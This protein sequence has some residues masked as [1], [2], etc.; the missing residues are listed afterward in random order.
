[1]LKNKVLIF[2]GLIIFLILGSKANSSQSLLI[3]P[4]SLSLNIPSGRLDTSYIEVTNSSN[5][6]TFI[7]SCFDSDWMILF[8][9]EFKLR[10]KETK[11]I[12]AIF[13]VPRGEDPERAGKIIFKTK[14][15]TR[16]ANIK[17][18]ILD[19]MRER[20]EKVAKIEKKQEENEQIKQEVEKEINNLKEKIE[21]FVKTLKEE[22][23]KKEIE[24][25]N[26]IPTSFY[27][28]EKRIE[29]MEHVYEYLADNL[30]EEIKNGEI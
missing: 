28:G 21:Y 24:E 30:R 4:N 17:V 10:P 1:M 16:Q 5:T 13:F 29:E 25:I 9:S 27:P 15:G 22:L 7:N 23:Q 2:S 26:N 18:N 8:P 12:L 20:V 6:F 14:N 11:R 19:P 3:N